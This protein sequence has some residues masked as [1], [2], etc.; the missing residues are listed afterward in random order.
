[1]LAQLTQNISPAFNTLCDDGKRSVAAVLTV[2]IG[3]A[4]VILLMSIGVAVQQGTNT[5]MESL[6]TAAVADGGEYRAV[7]QHSTFAMENNVFANYRSLN[8]IEDFTA[9]MTMG[10][11]FIIG[12][13][14]LVTAGFMALHFG[15]KALAGLPKLFEQ[16]SAPLQ[17]WIESAMLTLAGSAVGIGVAFLSTRYANQLLENMTLQIHVPSVALTFLVMLGIV[18]LLRTGRHVIGR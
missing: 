13:T 7:S 5:Q 2:I 4:A 6:A 17:F 1:M 15:M 11:A 16:Q 12:A 9:L 14:L 18:T 10:F 3:T 8:A